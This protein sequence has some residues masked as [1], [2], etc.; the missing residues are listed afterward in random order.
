MPVEN[1]NLEPLKLLTDLAAQ[2]RGV[3]IVDIENIAAEDGLPYRIPI[4]IK[5]GQQPEVVGLKSLFEAWRDRPSAKRGTATA[6]TLQSFIDLTNRHHTPHSVVF[7]DTDW[8]KPSLLAVIDY[9]EKAAEPVE[10]EIGQPSDGTTERLEEAVGTYTP[11]P[12][13]LRH[14]IVYAYPLSDTWKEWVRMN[15]EPMT[16]GEFAAWIEDHIADL[17]SP[18]DAERI[19]MERDF[20]TTVATPSALIQISRGLQINVEAKVKNIV[21]LQS[22]AAQ[23][24]FEENHLGSD[25]KPLVIPGMFLLQVAPFFGGDVVRVPVRLRYRVAGGVTKW[26]FAMHRPDLAITQRLTDDLLY[27]RRDTGLPVYEGAP[28]A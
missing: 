18:E 14:R 26:F 5:H 7:A 17:S 24:A 4:G 2:A 22:G 20:Q 25:G 9:H 21:T 12:D 6:L 11:R 10:G 8:R 23:I 19:W 15:G 13:N 28:E 1:T 3:E 16:Q 27:V